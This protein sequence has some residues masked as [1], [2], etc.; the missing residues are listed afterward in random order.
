M[1]SGSIRISNPSIQERIMNLVGFS[2]EEAQVKFGFLL[3]A[4]KFG[5]PIHGGMGIG[6]D[7]LISLMLGITDI[8]EVIAFPKTNQATDLM[9]D[10]P[11]EVVQ[12][13]LDQLHIALA[14]PEEEWEE[15]D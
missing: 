12:Q 1:A 6:M 2:K 10:S 3:E 13:Q 7:R 8:R 15:S 14:L 5:G 9:S 11:T 4:Y